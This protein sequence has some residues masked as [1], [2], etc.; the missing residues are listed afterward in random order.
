MTSRG[1]GG[2]LGPGVIYI[3]RGTRGTIIDISSYEIVSYLDL[4]DIDMR[5]IRPA[6]PG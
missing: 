4:F 1:R 5:S 3:G 6:N 2:V